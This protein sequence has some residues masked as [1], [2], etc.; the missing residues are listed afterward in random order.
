MQIWFKLLVDIYKKKKKN[1]KRHFS[2]C[3]PDFYY[4]SKRIF[5]LF[6]LF[7]LSATDALNLSTVGSHTRNSVCS[8]T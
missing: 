4:N 7:L 1:I 8:I 6:M 3:N 5:R 2:Y